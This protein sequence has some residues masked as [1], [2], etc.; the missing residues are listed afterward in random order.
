MLKFLWND[1]RKKE[2]K[3]ILDFMNKVKNSTIAI[4]MLGN[5]VTDNKKIK[6]SFSVILL[7]VRDEQLCEL[8]S[9]VNKVQHWKKWNR[10]VHLR[11][12]PIL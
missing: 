9:R 1:K 12:V 7:F 6:K 2:R 8:T 10:I 3:E 4:V 5:E 11:N